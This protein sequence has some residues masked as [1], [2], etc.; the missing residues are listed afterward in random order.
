MIPYPS[1]HLAEL[2]VYITSTRVDLYSHQI[3][4][5]D[6]ITKAVVVEIAISHFVHIFGLSDILVNSQPDTMLE[7]GHPGI[8][9]EQ[10]VTAP[11]TLGT[12][13]SG[14]IRTLSVPTDSTGT[15]KRVCWY[16]RATTLGRRYRT[17]EGTITRLVT[18]F[19]EIEYDLILDIRCQWLCSIFI[20][21][22]IFQ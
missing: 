10:P 20:F 14:T 7:V 1:G 19:E 17:I 12:E 21:N 22:Q 13:S 8:I 15:I 5:C 9:S 6:G 4:L 18:N 2:I 3:L 16:E 11:F